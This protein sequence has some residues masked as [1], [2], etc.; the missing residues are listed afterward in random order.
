MTDEQ[1]VV[2]YKEMIKGLTESNTQHFE[3]TEGE[4]TR[5]YW[6][7]GVLWEGKKLL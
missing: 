7:G 2:S 1:E 3:I 5:I 6:K 4:L